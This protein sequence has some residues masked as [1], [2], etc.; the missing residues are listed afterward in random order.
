MG[1]VTKLKSNY[2]KTYHDLYQEIYYDKITAIDLA[3]KEGLEELQVD[4]IAKLLYI[5][6]LEVKEI[7]QKCQIDKI[8]LFTFFQILLQGSS[9]IC[10]MLKKELQC[11][12]PLEY[13][14]EDIA[15]IY[16]ISLETLREAAEKYGKYLIPSSELQ[17][18]FKH[19]VLTGNL[20]KYQ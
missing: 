4:E 8:N 3:I 19:V 5:S 10:S 1:T 9:E 6:E 16:D 18:F 13:C 15:F 17:G 2:K 20:Y 12:S 14:L 11:G 7:I